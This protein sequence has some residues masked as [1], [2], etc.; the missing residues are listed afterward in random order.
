MS[1]SQYYLSECLQVA[2]KSPMCFTLGAIMVKGGKVISRGY[3]HYRP[4]YDGAE[5]HTHGFRK[6]VSMHA[7]MH[8]IL[9]C[10]GMT[11]SFKTQLQGI[12]RRVLR[13]KPKQRKQ[14]RK[15]R[16]SESSCN[17]LSHSAP[18]RAVQ[19]RR[20]PRMN[21]AD[22]YVARV[23]KQG[24]GCAKPCWRCLEWA[25]WA[26]IKRIFH[27]DEG[28]GRFE[29]VKVNAVQVEPYGTSSDVRLFAG[30]V[31]SYHISNSKTLILCNRNCKH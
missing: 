4:N 27:W 13:T 8:A 7:E 14:V 12:E 3:N 5:V 2:T 28:L 31:R 11:P 15:Q 10:T 20:D 16:Q 9:N 6:P 18:V 25:R 1:K 22:L 21:G 26:G 19:V 23:T 24:M 29:V 30:L 17:S